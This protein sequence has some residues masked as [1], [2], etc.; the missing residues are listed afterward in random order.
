MR[1]LRSS[2]LPT[3]VALGLFA[4]WAA[5]RRAPFE[6]AA[7]TAEIRLAA[8]D[9]AVG[10]VL[11]AAGLTAWWRRPQS[12]TGLLLCLAGFTW[13]LGTF[14]GSGWHGYADFG[15]FFLTL[16]RGLLA[17][18]LLSYPSG[19]LER[20]YERAG[21][22]AAYVLSVVGYV[23]ETPAAALALAARPGRGRR[24]TL[25]S[26]LRPRPPRAGHGPRR[27]R[28]AG[29]GARRVRGCAA[30]RFL[31]L[32][33]LAVRRR[34]RSDCRHPCARPRAGPVGGYD[35][36]RSRRGSRRGRRIRDVARPTRRCPRRPIAPAGIP[37]GRRARLPSTRKA[38]S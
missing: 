13:F 12:R 14:A 6:P 9:L 36:D 32:V 25:R 2:L 38:A 37:A 4:E 18:T 20:R 30:D 26:L 31:R 3:A 5:L 11:V 7:S 21:V 23:G 1:T 28:R 17:H 15:T 16:N 27:M 29:C 22:A 34:D 8:A 10:I 19:R 33:R 24:R 35:G